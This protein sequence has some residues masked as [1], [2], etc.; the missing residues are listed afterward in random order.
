MSKTPIV[1][2]LWFDTQ[3]E[4]AAKFYIETFGDGRVTAVAHYPETVETP[5][6]NPKGSVLTVDFEVA[7]QAFTALNAGPA[8]VKNP[9]ISFFVQVESREEADRFYA[10]FAEGG[11]VL[12]PL[13]AYPWSER[14]AWVEDRFGV[15]WQIITGRRPK[16]SGTIATCLMFSGPVG[17]KAS[18]AM[19]SYARIF[20]HGRMTQIERYTAEEG[21]EGWVKHGRFQ[22][23]GQEIIAMDSPI[24]HAFG[25]NDGISLQVFCANQAEV[26]AYWAALSE[27]GEAGPCGWLKDRFGVSWQIVPA[28]I[29]E[30]ITTADKAA[31]DRVFEA[32]L[33][34]E[35]LEIATLERA[36]EGR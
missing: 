1:P 15:S 21:N 33:R 34:M 8:I 13:D 35:K 22:L 7:G 27:G 31:R 32:I 29:T 30:W 20:P 25:F 3:A 26:D 28:R 12:M 19:E 14:Y 6:P 16:E 9:A 10:A 18:S 2:C 17:G 4:E 36:F 23:D 11:K 24:P 5:S